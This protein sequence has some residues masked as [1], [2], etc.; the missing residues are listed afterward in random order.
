MFIKVGNQK[1]INLD[2]TGVL[3]TKVDENPEH[4]AHAIYYGK[5]TDKYALVHYPT[6]KECH[7]AFEK[8]MSS[9][10]AGDVVCE[11]PPED[12][13][14]YKTIEV[15]KS[16]GKPV[17]FRYSPECM[18]DFLKLFYIQSKGHGHRIDAAHYYTYITEKYKEQTKAADDLEAF[19]QA[20]RNELPKYVFTLDVF[21]KDWCD[22]D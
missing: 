9:I 5:K 22:D 16:S 4:C 17:T 20:V 12:Q 13:S 10:I 15:V 11:I 21:K 18:D 2:H 1:S 8:I 19:K 3:T 14:M 6:E 7:E